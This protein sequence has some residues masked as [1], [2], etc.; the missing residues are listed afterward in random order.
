MTLI[1]H[2]LSHLHEFVEIVVAEASL[3]LHG[4]HPAHVFP[5]ST[6]FLLL[7]FVCRVE[8]LP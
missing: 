8:C 4:H 5:V 1:S 3:S 6:G 7:L 2:Y